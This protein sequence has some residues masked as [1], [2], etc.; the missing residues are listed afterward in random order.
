MYPY[1]A[2]TQSSRLNNPERLTHHG[3]GGTPLSAMI[4][5]TAYRS[6]TAI[7]RWI[8]E[9]KNRRVR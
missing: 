9:L 1:D 3:G 7:E 4:S 8:T 2:L 6:V 5:S